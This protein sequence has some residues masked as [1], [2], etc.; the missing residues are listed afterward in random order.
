MRDLPSRPRVVVAGGGHNGLVCA[1]YLARAG[2]DVEVL[3]ARATVGGCASTVD[4]LG[5]RVNVCS[6]DHTMIRGCGIVEELGLAAHGLRYLDLEPAGHSVVVGAGSSWWSFADTE[7]TLESLSLTHPG[8]V[9]GYRR[10]LEAMLPKARAVVA[11]TSAR[12]SAVQAW[13]RAGRHGPGLVRLARASAA[14]VLHQ[15]FDDEALLAPCAALGPAVWGL[16]PALPGTGL[17]A[18]GYALRHVVGPGRP[19]GGSGSLPAA[20]RA[21][22]EAAGGRVRTGATVRKVVC[23]GGQVA[24]VELA[25]SEQVSADVVICA[26]DP[27]TAIVDWV[28]PGTPGAMGRLAAAWAARPVGE[29]YESKVDALVQGVPRYLEDD[30]EVASRLGITN[31]VA[32]S[33]ITPS[34]AGIARARTAADRG[35]V[36][37]QPVM[38]VNVPSVADPTMAVDGTHVFSLEVLFTPYRLAGGWDAS[39]EPQRWL[40]VFGRHVDAGFRERVGAWRVVTPVDYERQFGLRRGHAPSFSGGPLSVLAGWRD[41]ELTRYETPVTGLFLTGAGTYP[42]AGVWGASGR[43]TAA[44]VLSRLGQR[45]H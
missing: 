39:Q 13:R 45:A 34:L 8:Q 29:G 2:L 24:G 43:N 31:G 12:P 42:G 27:R 21:A 11:L 28:G 40:D 19:A 6:C 22:V 26:T 20:L 7:R 38:L 3:E 16:D 32:T 41:R 30:A 23:T 14:D 4:A 44:V 36:A 15:F 35:A 10:Y 37:D 18:L 17:G 33:V 9:A 5:A 25:G 1:A